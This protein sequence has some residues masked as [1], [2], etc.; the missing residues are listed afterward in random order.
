VFVVCSLQEGHVSL[1][2][3]DKGLTHELFHP[4]KAVCGEVGSRVVLADIDAVVTCFG[5]MHPSLSKSCSHAG[6]RVRNCPYAAD[7][8][9]DDTQRC[10]CCREC[11]HECAMDI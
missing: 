11:A 5:C 1:V 8:R 6:A 4:D 9:N 7:I 2:V 10:S 3:D